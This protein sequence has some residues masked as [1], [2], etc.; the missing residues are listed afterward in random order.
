MIE[1]HGRQFA[2]RA[3]LRRF[4]FQ[5]ARKP[6]KDLRTRKELR[7]CVT[8][9]Q[10]QLDTHSHETRKALNAKVQM[11]Q[12]ANKEQQNK[13]FDLENKILDLEKEITALSTENKKL[14]EDLDAIK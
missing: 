9:L 8:L 5:Q 4:E 3:E 6:P 1:K 11:L 13:I 7:D 14:K 12:K 10:S 2:S